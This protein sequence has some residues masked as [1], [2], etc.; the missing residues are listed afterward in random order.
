MGR[1]LKIIIG[2]GILVSGFALLFLGKITESGLGL[3]F[4]SASLFILQI[5]KFIQARKETEMKQ[6]IKADLRKS[7]P[8]GGIKKP[9]LD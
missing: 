7:I 9:P 1:F 4:G 5:E 2:V 8:G 6:D 3:V